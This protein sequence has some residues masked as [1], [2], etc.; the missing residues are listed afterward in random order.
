MQACF[1]F[2]VQDLQGPEQD[3]RR[4]L[5]YHVLLLLEIGLKY[6]DVSYCDVK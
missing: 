1:F 5:E 3:G 4:L 6:E 2:S